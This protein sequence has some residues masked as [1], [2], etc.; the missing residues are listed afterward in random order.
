MTY[1]AKVKIMVH[2]AN[3]YMDMSASYKRLWIALTSPSLNQLNIV[4]VLIQQ[5]KKLDRLKALKSPTEQ[6]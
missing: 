3:D 2:P 5:H 1:V 6:G 4:N